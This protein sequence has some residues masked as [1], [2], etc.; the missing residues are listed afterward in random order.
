VEE[1]ALPKSKE[2]KLIKQGT[3]K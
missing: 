1:L 3:A 2:S